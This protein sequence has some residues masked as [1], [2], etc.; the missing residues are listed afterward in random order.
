VRLKCH[1]CR[2]FVRVSYDGAKLAAEVL[3]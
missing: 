1:K 3:Y 2:R